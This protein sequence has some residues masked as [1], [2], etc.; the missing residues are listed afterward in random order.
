MQNINFQL[1]NLIYQSQHMNNPLIIPWKSF[2]DYK[3]NKTEIGLFLMLLDIRIMDISFF[4]ISWVF[5]FRSYGLINMEESYHRE[6]V[7]GVYRNTILHIRFMEYT[8]YSPEQ[9]IVLPIKH[10]I[11][12]S[13]KNICLEQ[14]F[15]K[16]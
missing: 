5:L 12:V 14:W 8:W 9:Y 15:S 13:N 11:Q 3:I 16:P 2:L 7:L 4:C 6:E 1:V 10:N